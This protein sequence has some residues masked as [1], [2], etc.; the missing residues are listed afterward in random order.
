[1]YLGLRIGETLALNINDIDIEKQ[2]INVNKTLTL[3]K[4]NEVIMG[5]TTKTYASKRTIPIP[6]F[7]I[8][9]I[10]EQLEKKTRIICYFYIMI[11]IYLIQLQIVD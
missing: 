7:L 11:I 10:K 4:D 9:S 3:G 1:M 6:D 5:D 2:I 8:P